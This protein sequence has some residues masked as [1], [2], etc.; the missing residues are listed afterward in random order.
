MENRFHVEPHERRVVEAYELDAAIKIY[1][2]HGGGQAWIDRVEADRQKLSA[3]LIDSPQVKQGS[4]P[5]S[6]KGMDASFRKERDTWII[7]NG[8]HFQRL[9]STKGLAYLAQLLSAPHHEIH[10]LALAGADSANGDGGEVLDSQA[11]AEYRRISELGTE[12]AEAERFNDLGR[13]AKL[14]E[15]I[16]AIG[17]HLAGAIRLGGRTRR[18]TSDAERARVAV[19]KRIKA[20]IAQIREVDD[21]LGRHLTT[22]VVTGNFCC[23]RPDPADR[24]DWTF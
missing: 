18:S 9:K 13:A 8:N 23:Y 21:Y 14:R 2:D 19:T 7:G 22:S 5:Q 1:H 6:S 12:L 24:V 4:D 10:A 3:R 15:E 16:E 17:A 20:A 11:L